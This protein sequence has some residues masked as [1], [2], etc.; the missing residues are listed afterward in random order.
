MND[1]LRTRAATTSMILGPALLVAGTAI[2]PKTPA[3]PGPD[4]AELAAH[5][6]RF[7][8]GAVLFVV[9]HL[10]LAGGLVALLRATNGKVTLVAGA[11][12]AWGAAV[13]G[14]PRVHP[15]LR[16]RRRRDGRARGRGRGARAPQRDAGCLVLILS[17]WP[18]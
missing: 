11:A 16:G 15:T 18:G 9:G 1:D 2:T 4:L 7:A 6:T 13:F 17:G 8:V 14:W 5:E 10:L 12:T 3:E